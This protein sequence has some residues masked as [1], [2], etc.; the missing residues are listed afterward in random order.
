MPEMDGAEL[1]RRVRMLRPGPGIPA[2]MVTGYVKDRASLDALDVEVLRKPF[3]LGA[4]VRDLL[5]L[6]QEAPHPREAAPRA[7]FG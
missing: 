6:T 1:L 5:G 7:A 4:R 2:L 3:P